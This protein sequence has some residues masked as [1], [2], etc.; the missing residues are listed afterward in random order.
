MKNSSSPSRHRAPARTVHWLANHIRVWFTSQ[1]SA[2]SSPTVASMHR[3]SRGHGSSHTSGGCGGR[4]RSSSRS[5]G[6]PSRPKRA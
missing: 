6:R 4:A 5:A 3:M 1:P 2:C